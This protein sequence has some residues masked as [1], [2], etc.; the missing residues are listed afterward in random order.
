MRSLF[1]IL[2]SLCFGGPSLCLAQTGLAPVLYT[3][4]GSVYTQNF[5]GLPA[6][7]SFSLTG[8]G[9]FTLSE[10][11]IRA[12]NLGG[13]QLLMTAGSNAN[14]SFATGTGS[15]TGNGVYSLGN[16]GST[17]RA[18]GSLASGTGIYAFGLIL[19]NQTGSIL[20][21]F[22]VSFTAEQWRKGGASNKNTWSFRYKTGTMTQIADTGLI[23]EPRL[24]FSSLTSTS[25]ASSLNGNLPD[26]R[27]RISVTLTGISWKKGEQLLLRWDDADENGSD[28]VMA[29]DDLSFSADLNSGPPLLSD[30]N[31]DSITSRSALLSVLADDHFQST[32]LRLYYDTSLTFQNPTMLRPVPDT[33]PAG[34]GNMVIT[35]KVNGLLSGRSYYYYFT[36]ANLHGR[37]SSSIKSFTTTVEAPSVTTLA[38]SSIT[39]SSAVWEGSVSDEGGAPVTDR[40]FTW[41]IVGNS[42]SEEQDIAMG[43]GLGNFSQ[44]IR[45]LPSGKQIEV[46][47]Y[48]I[49]SGGRSYGRAYTFVTPVTILSLGSSSNTRTNAHQ[50]TFLLHTSHT[51][52]GLLT[53]HFAP[54]SETITEAS[55]TSIAG[56]TSRYTI[57][58]STG[59]G[60]GIL[61]IR[62]L[63]DSGTSV[64]IDNTPYTATTSY[65]IDKTPPQI[66]QIHVPDTPVK[67][68]DTIRASLS[69]MPDTENF[70]LLSG[71]IAGFPL[72][73]LTKLNDSCYTAYSIVTHNGKEVD[74]ADS[75]PVMIFL[76]DETGNTS[77]S[78][79]GIHQSNDRI[80]ARK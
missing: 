41:K 18:L 26:N 61:S 78:Q 16:A 50:V 21:S 9:P 65:Q 73:D 49:N 80:D 32:S 36:A 76:Q 15:S 3:T 62:F 4:A 63:H 34:S 38:P 31:A 20:N 48:A 64:P 75:I 46:R 19:T 42:T 22:T 25:P 5:D 23:V 7:G 14:A 52:N 55:I 71:T 70:R 13:W 11:P 17:D 30:P 57:T 56:D 1:L 54:V 6:S 33:L 43:S 35:A 67:I 8:K 77:V 60:D 29:M 58:V 2:A 24:D 39:S 45:G 27:Q 51:I 37:D 47:A 44:T 69:V 59:K 53:S 28:D 74:A 68:G 79:L 10:P 66:R 72:M 12:L 40:G